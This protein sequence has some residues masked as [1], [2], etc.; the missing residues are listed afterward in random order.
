[1]S[2]FRQKVNKPPPPK[3][4][5]SNPTFTCLDFVSNE[6][7][8]NTGEYIALHIDLDRQTVRSN[9]LH[10]YVEDVE[11]EQDCNNNSVLD[12]QSNE[13]NT[14][15]LAQLAQNEDV[16]SDQQET[17]PSNSPCQSL[18]GPPEM[19]KDDS[20]DRN[21]PRCMSTE[22]RSDTSSSTAVA[23]MQTDS[24][25]SQHV[26]QSDTNYKT[27]QQAHDGKDDMRGIEFFNGSIN[28]VIYVGKRGNTEWSREKLKTL[29]F[30]NPNNKVY[31]LR[32][33][34]EASLAAISEELKLR[35]NLR[36]LIVTY[37]GKHI[38][39]TRTS[40]Y[41]D[42]SAFLCFE[43]EIDTSVLVDG[44]HSGT[45]LIIPS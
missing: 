28:Y 3:L 36:N 41:D 33:S 7:C 4:E 11:L 23:P 31:C 38:V 40:I 34:C 1:M 22:T 25:S 43:Q 15:C 17:I 26:C 39:D 21:T 19:V 10:H 2:T 14:A 45:T 8:D 5:S 29:F 24:S 6:A 32:L 35:W 9:R 44:C 37:E 16:L 18:L 20:L 27:L 12:A 42:L 30:I 13:N